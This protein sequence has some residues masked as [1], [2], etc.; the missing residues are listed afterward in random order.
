MSLPIERF[1][2]PADPYLVR[3]VSD[4]PTDTPPERVLLGNGWLRRSDCATFISSAGAGKSVGMTQAAIAWGLGLPYFGIHPAHPLRVLLFSG[5]DDDVTLGQCREGLLDHGEAVTGRRIERGELVAL[6]DTLRVDFSREHVGDRFH[7]RLAKLLSEEPADLVLV[8]PLFTYVGGD[9]VKEASHWF[10]VGLLPIL[11][12]HDAAAIVASHTNRMAKDS[13][14]N[15]DDIY[16]GIGGG[17]IANIPRSVLTLRPTKDDGLFVLKVG[18]RQTTGWKDGDGNFTPAYFLRR[19]SDPSRPAWLPV[20]H[21]EATELL[22]EAGTGTKH[23]KCTPADAL[24]CL[25]TGAM[26][27]PQ[28]LESMKRRCGCGLSAAKTALAEARRNEAVHEWEE[29]NPN[30]GKAVLW[31]CLPE[32]KE[33]WL[34]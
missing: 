32:H 21:D 6:S 9:I 14:D 16:S 28:L 10:R 22:D 12:E 13:W 3:G 33:Q 20:A 31:F 15:T 5:E 18:K 19:S 2:P 17:E 34:K 25:A 7:G 11:Q 29:P 8:N 23:R 1:E 4:F 24:A 26:A 30:G 27:R